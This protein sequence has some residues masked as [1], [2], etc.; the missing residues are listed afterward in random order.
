MPECRW[1]WAL[2]GAAGLAHRAGVRT[3]GLAAKLEDAKTAWRQGYDKWLDWA[4]R[5]DSDS[6]SA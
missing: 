2:N 1:F 4:G 5:R 6:K 3:S